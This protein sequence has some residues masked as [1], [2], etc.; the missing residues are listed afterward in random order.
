MIDTAQAYDYSDYYNY[1]NYYHN[2]YD[3]TG[4]TTTA[5]S[6]NHHSYP[7]NAYFTYNPNS[8]AP[9]E[10]DNPLQNNQPIQSVFQPTADFSKQMPV[11]P[12]YN[13]VVNHITNHLSPQFVSGRI[14]SNSS[15]SSASSSI[16]SPDTGLATKTGSSFS[17]DNS[18]SKSSSPKKVSNLAKKTT[19]LAKLAPSYRPPQSAHGSQFS[20]SSVESVSVQLANKSLWSK[21]ASHQTE[22]I[23][24]KQ[25]R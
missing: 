3:S 14:S 1:A 22:M 17:S 13:Y 15:I 25:G 6:Q 18:S 24:T 2:N 21:F 11:Y 7:P 10:L 9:V 20:P 4:T 16:C 23:I 5:E 19:K 8:Y 12:T